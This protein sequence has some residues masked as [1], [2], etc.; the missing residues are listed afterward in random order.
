MTKPLPN[1]QGSIADK[2]SKSHDSR[3]EA[4]EEQT[5]RDCLAG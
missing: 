2:E 3:D 5:S 4:P 1:K